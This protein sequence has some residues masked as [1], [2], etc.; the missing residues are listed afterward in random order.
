MT[1]E[2]LLKIYGGIQ[3]SMLPESIHFVWSPDPIKVEFEGETLLFEWQ[4][5]E[6]RD[7]FTKYKLFLYEGEKNVDNLRITAYYSTEDDKLR[8]IDREIWGSVMNEQGES[9]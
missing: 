2:R 1:L 8:Y 5:R 3:P 9:K 6:P 7:A 4:K